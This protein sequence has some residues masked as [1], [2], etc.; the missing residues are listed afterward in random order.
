MTGL[1]LASYVVTGVPLIL[2]TA[3]DIFRRILAIAL[4]VLAVAYVRP[5]HVGCSARSGPF[6]NHS[7]WWAVRLS[8]GL[9]TIINGVF[10]DVTPRGSCKNR[11]FGGT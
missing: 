7:G 1:C 9:N 3:E 10:W 11:R 4:W 5:A 8:L 6:S 2:A